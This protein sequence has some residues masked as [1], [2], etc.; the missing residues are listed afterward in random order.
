MPRKPPENKEDVGCKPPPSIC[1]CPR[2]K[3]A[4]WYPLVYWNGTAKKWSFKCQAHDKIF[5][6]DTGV[7]RRNSSYWIVAMGEVIGNMN[8]DKGYT[9]VRDA[10]SA[11]TAYMVNKKYLPNYRSNTSLHSDKAY[12]QSIVE[13]RCRRSEVVSTH[14]QCNGSV[15]SVSVDITRPR[16]EWDSSILIGE[17]PRDLRQKLEAVTRNYFKRASTGCSLIQSNNVVTTNIPGGDEVSDPYAD[18]PPLPTFDEE[19]IVVIN[20]DVGNIMDFIEKNPVVTATDIL[21][22]LGTHPTQDDSYKVTAIEILNTLGTHSNNIIDD[23]YVQPN[24]LSQ[25]ELY[26]IKSKVNGTCVSSNYDPTTV[27]MAINQV[28]KVYETLRCDNK[29]CDCM[30]GTKYPEGKYVRNGVF[31]ISG[32]GKEHTID[33]ENLRKHNIM[34][35]QLECDSVTKYVMNRARLSIVEHTRNIGEASHLEYKTQ[36]AFDGDIRPTKFWPKTKR[37]IT[38]ILPGTQHHADKLAKRKVEAK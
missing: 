11:L 22:T 14:G 18:C 30:T 37:R 33:H 10:T 9:N 31:Y 3:D 25:Q 26:E 13:S 38:N 23:S 19:G 17:F 36:K 2:D 32:H 24:L 16:F 28:S 7:Y 29:E 21:D 1:R 12:E 8:T 6:G 35:T 15:S 27:M 20:P 34:L 4:R 5:Y